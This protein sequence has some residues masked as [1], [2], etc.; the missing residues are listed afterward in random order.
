MKN[1]LKGAMISLAIIVCSSNLELNSQVLKYRITKKEDISFMG[2]SRMVYRII[3]E[4]S[5]VP[6]EKEL[7]NTATQI[8][9]N[10]NKTW[11]EF[12]V[13]M[14]MP[15]M[16]IEST[17][18]GVGEF[19][20][21][22]LLRFNRN[23]YTLT[24]TKWETKKTPQPVKE[25]TPSKLK[26]YKIDISAINIGESKVKINIATNFPDGTNLFLSIYRI[27]F[28]KGDTET[29]TGDLGEKVFSV[30][31][32][33]F[34][35][36]MTISDTEWYNRYQ[37]VVKSIPNDFPPISKISENIFIDVM[38]TLTCQ[39]QTSISINLIPKMLFL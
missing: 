32:G 12:T 38:Y 17:A 5:S 8:W 7:K 3:L 14:Y 39:N 4:V 37:K 27:Y 16:D 23:E 6:T 26:E 24:G 2:T 36:I 29:Y 25:T 1:I 33:Q 19:R 22:G 28:V 21:N 9:G 20:P 15:E 13:F 30:K 31:N 35:T 18:F 11:Q 34:E 10:G